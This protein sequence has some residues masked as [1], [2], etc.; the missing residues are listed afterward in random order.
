MKVKV[1]FPP[2]PTG[3][4]H[5]GNAVTMIFNWLLAKKN[6]GKIIMRLEDTDTERSSKEFEEDIL[7]SL[8]WLGLK[9]DEGIYRQTERLDIYRGYLQQLLDKKKAFYCFH[10]KEELEEERHQQ[11][12]DKLSPQHVC[13]HKK[14]PPA[15][16][17]QKGIIRLAVD[18]H[19]DR[20]ISFDDK[21]RGQIDFRQSLLGDFAIARSIDSPLYHFAVSIDDGTMGI[22]HVIRGEDHISNTPKQIL[23]YE[24]LDLPVPIFAH[25]PLL[26]GSDKS[27]L[28]KRH[29]ATAVSMYRKDYLP[30]AL[31][32]FLA[33]I[34]HT[35]SKDVL[36]R[37]EMIQEF[38]LSKVH[39]SG[40]IFDVKKLNWINSQYIKKLSPEEFK[41]VSG[42]PEIPDTAVPLI[43][44]RLE[45][46][47]DAQGFDY[48]WKE[49]EYD[50]ELLKWK[51]ADLPRSKAALEKVLEILNQLDFEEKKLRNALDELGQELGDRGL[52]YWPLRVALSGKDKS[53]DPVEVA[54][55]L[56]KDVVLQRID[57]AIRKLD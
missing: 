44:E 47:S 52:V 43:T 40:A 12:D 14:K 42:M 3:N 29:G 26:L 11:I 48:F 10:T 38:E 28:S 35:F 27:K 45:K 23:I 54:V 34:S 25:L 53:P 41:K 37:E 17:T 22:T 30:D 5:V 55:V 8:K 18:S 33:G 1:R 36:S 19:S 32:N 7:N 2:S 4:L 50:K 39:K 57:K 51:K 31:F 13:A 20:I 6:D 46:L 15:V 56:K 49:P 21:I 16:P 24:A 9:W